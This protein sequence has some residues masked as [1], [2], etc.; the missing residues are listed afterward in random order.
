MMELLKRFED[1]DGKA[2]FDDLINEQD[3]GIEDDGANE[4]SVKLAG[5]DISESRLCLRAREVVSELF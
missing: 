1:E 2:E 5:V 3:D 4:L